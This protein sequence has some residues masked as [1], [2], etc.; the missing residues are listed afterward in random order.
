M[1]L[2]ANV[3]ATYSVATIACCVINFALLFCIKKTPSLFILI[4]S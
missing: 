4:S 3:K 1:K 2:S